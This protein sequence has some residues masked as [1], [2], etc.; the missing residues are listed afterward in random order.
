MS[1]TSPKSSAAR[2]ASWAKFRAKNVEKRNEATRLWR[3]N[4]ATADAEYYQKNRERVLEYSRTY[5]K[6]NAGKVNSWTRKRQLAKLNR[7]PQW[8]TSQHLAD[9]EAYYTTAKE[10]Q[11]LSEDILTV[12]HI[13]PLQ[14]KDVSGLHVPWNLQILPMK[15]NSS[16]GRKCNKS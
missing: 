9:M 8:L 4:N 15:M 12:D 14:G 1:R 6:V 16:K 2:R 13:T 11:W 5:R 10:L 7:T 3:K